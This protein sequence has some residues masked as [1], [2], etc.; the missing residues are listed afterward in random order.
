MILFLKIEISLGSQSKMVERVIIQQDNI[1]QNFSCFLQ[2]LSR[3]RKSARIVCKHTINLFGCC[4]GKDH[5]VSGY[6][7]PIVGLFPF[8]FFCITSYSP[9]F[10]RFLSMGHTKIR[11]TKRLSIDISQVALDAILGKCKRTYHDAMF[12]FH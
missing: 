5:R 8:D 1:W 12:P 9:E 6:K 10:C 7:L 4:L 3:A 2:S 11:N